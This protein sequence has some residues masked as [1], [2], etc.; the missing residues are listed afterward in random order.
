MTNHVH[1]LVTPSQEGA[2][3]NVMQSVGRRY[4]PYFNGRYRRTGALWEGRYRATLV[5]TDSYLLECYRYIE[6]N[7]VRAGL[8]EDPSDY[9]WSSCRV[10]ALGA[11][12][13]LVSP[14]DLYLALGTDSEARRLAYRAL[15]NLRLDEA[16]LVTIRDSTNKGWPLGSR[17]FREEIAALVRRRTAPLR[18]ERR[19]KDELGV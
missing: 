13:P 2:I 1:L 4:V 15:L 8:V 18:A 19:W 3:G 10:N 5:E 16:A 9:R 14:H 11:I 6:L 17:R 12:D 7:P